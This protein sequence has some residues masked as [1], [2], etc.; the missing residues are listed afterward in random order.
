MMFTSSNV[1]EVHI[2][3][4]SPPFIHSDSNLQIKRY[5]NYWKVQC[6][7]TIKTELLLNKWSK[8]ITV[9]PTASNWTE[10]RNLVVLG[11]SFIMTQGSLCQYNRVQILLTDGKRAIL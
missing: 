4:N 2:H 7:F 6:V 3:D 5:F 9:V 11:L 10:K 8:R 1:G